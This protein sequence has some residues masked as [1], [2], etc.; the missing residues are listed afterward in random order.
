MFTIKQSGGVIPLGILYNYSDGRTPVGWDV[1][2]NPVAG[3]FASEAG[4]DAATVIIGGWEMPYSHT[5]TLTP[6]TTG[7]FAGAIPLGNAMLHIINESA[8]VIVPRS[9]IVEVVSDVEMALSQAGGTITQAGG[10]L[11]I[12]KL[13]GNSGV[14]D[15]A[16]NAADIDVLMVNSSGNPVAVIAVEAVPNHDT[17]CKLAFAGLAIAGAIAE[18]DWQT[19]L[20]TDVFDV[21]L[22]E[23][24]HIG[25]WIQV[26]DSAETMIVTGVDGDTLTVTRGA[27]AEALEDS[28]VLNIL[29]RGST[30]NHEGGYDA[31]DTE[32]EVADGSIFT[33]GDTVSTPLS[34]IFTVVSVLGNVLTVTR[35]GEPDIIAD[36][37]TLIITNRSGTI[38][39]GNVWDDYSTR[40]TFNVTDSTDFRV[41]DVLKVT[42]SAEEMTIT[43]V[44]NA[45]DTI[46]VTR[47]ETPEALADDAVLNILNRVSPIPIGEYTAV[48]DSD[49]LD[50]APRNVGVKVVES[51]SYDQI[52]EVFDMKNIIQVPAQAKQLPVYFGSSGVSA[53]FVHINTKQVADFTAQRLVK[54]A[55]QYTGGTLLVVADKGEANAYWIDFPDW[56]PAGLYDVL[57]Y[58]GITPDAS[59]Q[60]AHRQTIEVVP[61]FR[62]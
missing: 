9:I 46:T 49:T 40:T 35:G 30:I 53:V 28:L 39:V 5:A 47:G 37:A 2:S 44:D 55:D 38:A 21:T 10:D 29:N 18:T 15:I 42:G 7:E 1:N 17:L 8:N 11:V 50:I 31:D 13:V 54:P 60:V 25:D 24:F 3:T 14:V 20:N 56:L 51:P 32:L 61:P 45:G 33:A 23:D 27:G 48:L 22:G 62:K 26:V 4:Y 59:A 34:E 41:G 57:I 16:A 58:D 19:P 12:G 36:E 43:G 52:S 6:K